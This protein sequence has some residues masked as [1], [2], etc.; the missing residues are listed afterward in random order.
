MKAVQVHFMSKEIQQK[1]ENMNELNSRKNEEDT[2]IT[3][4]KRRRNGPPVT[5]LI[6]PPSHLSCG[7][8]SAGSEVFAIVKRTKDVEWL[9]VLARMGRYDVSMAVA[10]NPNTQTETLRVLVSDSTLRE[11]EKSCIAEYPDSPNL[12]NVIARNLREEVAAHPNVTPD[13]LSGC[14][15]ELACVQRRR[16]ADDAGTSGEELA[17]LAKNPDGRIRFA[18]ASH[19]NTRAETLARLAF[20]TDGRVRYAVSLNPN[21]P[22]RAIDSILVRNSME[23]RR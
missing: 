14:E 15:E 8:I 22:Q 12:Y 5:P 17:Q 19:C 6:S 4:P 18:V 1:Q 11:I 10:E 7:P 3:Q 13:I 16:K 9:N 21:I 23:K 20:D 2:T